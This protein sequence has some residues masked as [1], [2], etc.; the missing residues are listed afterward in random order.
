MSNQLNQIE[1]I[2][3][4]LLVDVKNSD[5][6]LENLSIEQIDNLINKLI[7]LK[8]AIKKPEDKISKLWIKPSNSEN[9]PNNSNKNIARR[10]VV[11]IPSVPFEYTS[12]EHNIDSH[13]KSL[14]EQSQKISQDIENK[15]VS[16]KDTEPANY[17]DSITNTKT[18]IDLD[19]DYIYGP[20]YTYSSGGYIQMKTLSESKRK[21]YD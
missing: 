7:E 14:N 2:V 9:I 5:L 11:N 21:K 19:D 18:T 6:V 4:E 20:S 8:I 16:I 13:I 3:D 12:N 1:K 15:L 17:S 10:L